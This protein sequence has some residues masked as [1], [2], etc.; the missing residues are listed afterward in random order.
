MYSIIVFHLRDVYF[1]DIQLIKTNLNNF[2]TKFNRFVIT[3]YIK[4]IKRFINEKTI[5]FYI[6]RSI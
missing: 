3:N 4:R 1:N 5:L 6:E 2:G